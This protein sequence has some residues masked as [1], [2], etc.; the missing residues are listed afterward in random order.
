MLSRGLCDVP[1]FLPIAIPLKRK[2]SQGSY[3]QKRQKAG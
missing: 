2:V 1:Y 3:E